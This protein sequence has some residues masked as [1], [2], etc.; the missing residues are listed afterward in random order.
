MMTK[1]MLIVC[2]LAACLAARADMVQ[3]RTAV[4]NGQVTHVQGGSVFVKL[5]QGEFGVPMR[6]IV[7]VEL[8]RPAAYDKGLAALKAGKP[9]E[10]VAALKPLVDRLAGLPS[11]LV[12]DAVLRLGDA[13]LEMKDTKLAAAMF[14]KLKQLYPNSPQVHAVDV[15]NARVLFSVKKY[16][17]VIKVINNYLDPELKKDFLTA[18]QETTVAEALVLL[19][20][21]LLAKDKTYEALDCYMKVVTLYDFDDD[22]ATEA[23]FKAAGVLE[24]TGNWK[25][26]KEEYEDLVKESPDSPR[27]AEARK[28]IAEITK[29]HKE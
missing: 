29:A 15:K 18:D 9:Q 4:Y 13:Y 21:C 17:D 12:M 2:V 19:G 11:P 24:K 23:H 20:D 5:E 8:D 27:A 22:R 3:T 16:D 10:A 25:R 7:R 28:R 14:D 26:A 6:D 1:N